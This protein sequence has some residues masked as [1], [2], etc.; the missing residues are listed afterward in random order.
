MGVSQSGPVDKLKRNAFLYGILIISIAGGH[1]QP[2][3]GI[4]KK[5]AE[6]N[7]E[8]NESVNRSNLKRSLTYIIYRKF[9]ILPEK[10]PFVLNTF[11]FPDSFFNFFVRQSGQS[12]SFCWRVSPFEHIEINLDCFCKNTFL[13]A[14]FTALIQDRFRFILFADLSCFTQ[15]IQL[16]ADRCVDIFRLFQSALVFSHSAKCDSY[17]KI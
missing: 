15:K 1:Y 17:V 7:T 4:S 9:F 5:H 12:L 8:K 3:Y 16:S 6:I 2:F 14:F 10:S 11:I 13:N